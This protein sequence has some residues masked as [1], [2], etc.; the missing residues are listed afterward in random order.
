MNASKDQIERLRPVADDLTRLPGISL[1]VWMDGYDRNAV[2]S[3]ISRHQLTAR[4]FD[5]LDSI[6]GAFSGDWHYLVRQFR[7][8]G[9]AAEYYKG[10]S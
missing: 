1:R 2:Q 4:E 7:N 3:V 6:G 8:N 9:H 10:N 5:V